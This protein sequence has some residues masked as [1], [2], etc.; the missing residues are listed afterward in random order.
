MPQDGA[1]LVRHQSESDQAFDVRTE[2]TVQFTVI[3]PVYNGKETLR[4]CLDALAAQDLPVADY[5]VLVVDNG[6]TDGTWELIENYGPPVRGL[7]ETA[8]RGSYAARNAGIRESQGR[9]IAF[10]DADCVPKSTW[11]SLLLDGFND[12]GV[13]C[14]G[15]QVV[16]LE[17]TTPAEVFARR[18]GVLNQSMSFNGS[19]R[20]HFATANVAYRREVLDQLGGFEPSLES[21]G[22]ADLSWRM[23]EETDWAIR[24]QPEAI[25]EH[26]HRTNW[27]DLWKQY[28]RYGRG[29]A[30]LR[31]LHPTHPITH[32]E[33]L[34]ESARRLAR[35][36]RRAVTYG[37][38][39]PLAPIRGAASRDELDY[40]FYSFI[41]QAAF[42]L[43]ARRGPSRP[44]SRSMPSPTSAAGPAVSQ[45]A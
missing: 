2:T 7:R 5:E 12:P 25:V 35:L 1:A 21:G 36:G 30:A 33:M 10:T 22:D 28:H 8:I 34:S 38:T 3:V 32:Y 9:I 29:R 31:I 20:P 37:L 11:L 16:G 42:A 24:F 18:K 19:F 40:A 41:S 43:G 13:G 44:V 14:V 6:S 26:H 23:Q 15:G 39:K 4:G 45:R 27:R 17:P